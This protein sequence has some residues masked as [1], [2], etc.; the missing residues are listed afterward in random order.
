MKYSKDLFWSRL[1][2]EIFEENIQNEIIEKCFE[3]AKVFEEKYSRFIKW[4]YLSKLNDNKKAAITE[5]GKSL[6]NLTNRVSE[7]TSWYF[8]ITILPFLEN[9][10]YWI[11]KCKLVENIWYKNIKIIQ[12]E[13]ILEIST[14][15]VD[16][17]I[18]SPA[19]GILSEVLFKVGDVV[20]VKTKIATNN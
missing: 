20:P 13:I 8:D 6:I 19:A 9:L 3:T 10:W 11:E 17:E 1:D 15:K 18:P 2:L 7:L 16:S 12:D 4:N 5:E 14:D